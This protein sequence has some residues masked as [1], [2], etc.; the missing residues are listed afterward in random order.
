MKTNRIEDPLDLLSTIDRIDLGAELAECS[1]SLPSGVKGLRVQ[2][3]RTGHEASGTYQCHLV[4]DYIDTSGVRAT[5]FM[6]DSAQRV[7]G[8]IRVIRTLPF[9]PF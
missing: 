9:L 5:S 7:V 4:A 6:T 2:V 3:V 8:A 1:F